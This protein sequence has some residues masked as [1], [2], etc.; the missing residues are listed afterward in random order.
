M[1]PCGCSVQW[2]NFGAKG[3]SGHEHRLHAPENLPNARE[4]KKTKQTNNKKR[5]RER[6]RE[7]KKKKKKKRERERERESEREREREREKISTPQCEMVH[8]VS[9]A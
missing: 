5:E 7:K 3:G 8:R 9:V 6:E 1:P 2:S 4:Q